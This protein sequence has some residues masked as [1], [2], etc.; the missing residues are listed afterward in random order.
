MSHL[1]TSLSLLVTSLGLESVCIETVCQLKKGTQA[2]VQRLGCKE[3]ECSEPFA[4]A[5]AH[6]SSTPIISQGC[7]TYKTFIYGLTLSNQDLRLHASGILIVDLLLNVKLI[8]IH[9]FFVLSASS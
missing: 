8:T 1:N 6:G 5:E 9:D 3:Y 7:Y 4:V 2:S